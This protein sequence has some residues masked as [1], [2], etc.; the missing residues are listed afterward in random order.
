MD[1]V[2]IRDGSSTTDLRLGK[3]IPLLTSISN[4][5]SYCDDNN[6]TPSCYNIANL[7]LLLGTACGS[8]TPNEVVSSTNSIT[9]T[10][11]SNSQNAHRGFRGEYHQIGSTGTCVTYT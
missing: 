9:V 3:F 8:G 7:W 11:N 6:Y 10:F 5:V 2:M 1:V 4:V